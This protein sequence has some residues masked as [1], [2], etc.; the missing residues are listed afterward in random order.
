MFCVIGTEVYFRLKSVSV[1]F[2]FFWLLLFSFDVRDVTSEQ[3][4]SEVAWS[5][6]RVKSRTFF[7]FFGCVLEKP[8][9]LY[10]SGA[11]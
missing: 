11:R 8:R 9:M 5:C 6:Q 2:S 1:L 10:T 4:H 7:F 3:K